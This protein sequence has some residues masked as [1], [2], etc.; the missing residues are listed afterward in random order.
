MSCQH[1]NPLG[2]AFCGTCGGPL[3][4][5]RCR[6]GFIAGTDDIFCGRCGSSLAEPATQNGP[7]PV[8]TGQRFDL[9][10]LAQQAAKEQKFMESTHKVRVTQ[11]DI[12]KLLSTSRKKF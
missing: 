5:V 1:L 10:G 12:R 3:A 8:A 6:C 11:D 4:H 2:Y 7:S 9:Q